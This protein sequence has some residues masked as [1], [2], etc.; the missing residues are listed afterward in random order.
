MKKFLFHLTEKNSFFAMR[1]HDENLFKKNKGLCYTVFLIIII[2]TFYPLFLSG[3]GCP[4]DLNNYFVL[5]GGSISSNKQFLAELAGRFYYLII[6]PMYLVPYIS[7]NPVVIKLFHH[8]PLIAGFILFAII[9]FRL[10]HSKELSFFYFL[11]FL[12]IAQASRHTSLFLTYPFFFTFSFDLLLL[13]FLFLLN[14]FKNSGKYNLFLSVFLFTAGLLF[15]ES[16][17]LY[18][19]ILAIMIFAFR[20]KKG[21]NILQVL[22]HSFMIFL[23]FLVVG[24]LYVAAYL[25]YRIYHPSHYTGTSFDLNNLT[26]SNFFSAIWKLSITSYPLTVFTESGTLFTEKSELILGYSP[27]VL[28]L[29]LNARIEWIIKGICV[30]ITGFILLAGIARIKFKTLLAGILLSVLLIIIP[31]IP[32]ALSVKY[33]EYT[34]QHE[35][36]GYVCTFFSLF[37]TVLLIS[38]LIGYLINLLNF[39]FLLKRIMILLSAVCFFTFSVLTDFTNYS[40]AKDF[41]SD[42]L[43]LY[44]LDELM[45]T[46]TFLSIPPYSFFYTK[47]LYNS[48]SISAGGL[49]QQNFDWGYYMFIKTHV[50]QQSFRN[51]KDINVNNQDSIKPIYYLSMLQAEKSEEIMLV[52]AKMAPKGRKD[53]IPGQFT[54]KV[55]VLYYSPCKTFSVSFRCKDDTLNTDTELKVNQMERK[56]IPGKNFEMTIYNTKKNEAATFFSISLPDIDLKSIRISDIVDKDI[57][58]FYL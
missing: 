49:I 46:D 38:I 42:N 14:Y 58:V 25:I 10:M 51:Y 30:A 52:L 4:D 34:L 16:Y 53:T 6:H 40:I 15:Y 44:A 35:M 33:I 36:R 47:D 39:N 48:I 27:V 24:I 21:E 17:L 56:I 3:F 54:D 5:K 20:S 26:L 12:V 9:L 31:A 37:G 18:L 8:I 22:K 57:M 19:I 2:V 28:K 29:I 23:P 11:V 7:D 50:P 32:M 1:A 41:R 43:R 55:W 13:S 45:K